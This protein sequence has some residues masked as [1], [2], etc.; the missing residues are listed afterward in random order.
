MGAFLSPKR[1]RNKRK[2]S[3]GQINVATAGLSGSVL[4]A[5]GRFNPPQPCLS[6]LASDFCRRGLEICKIL[7]PEGIPVGAGPRK[8]R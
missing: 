4:H 5:C 6:P 2:F 1:W 7:P 3:P 8:S